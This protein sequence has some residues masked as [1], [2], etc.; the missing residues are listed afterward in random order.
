MATK[1]GNGSVEQIYFR[2]GKF[3]VS[4]E[5]MFNTITEDGLKSL[6]SI[7][8]PVQIIIGSSCGM[9]DALTYFGY[10]PVFRAIGE[11]EIIPEYNCVFK[12]A[13]DGKYYFDGFELVKK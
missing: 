8:Y 3:T 4:R 7:F 1:G 11:G 9:Y 10:S 6:F 13:K 5:S 2:K 12:A